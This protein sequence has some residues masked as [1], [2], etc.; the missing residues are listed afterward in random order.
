MAVA[1]LA[2]AATP[3]V[4]AGSQDAPGDRHGWLL[5]CEVALLTAVVA[6]L[7]LSREVSVAGYVASCIAVAGTLAIVL[8]T[9]FAT[10]QAAHDIRI[11]S[12]GLR[13]VSATVTDCHVTGRELGEDDDQVSYTY[14]CTYHWTVDGRAFSEEQSDADA[15]D[16]GR[17][18][19]VWLDGGRMIT[20]RPGGFAILIWIV[21]ALAGLL[22]VFRIGVNAFDTVHRAVVP[23][24]RAEDRGWTPGQ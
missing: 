9:V 1:V 15:S 7:P 8:G 4:W 10:A 13:S 20:Q 16:E 14:S 3:V 12:H 18:V 19:K 23:R 6:S 24:R 5:V 2:V 21:C 17:Q 11:R 22:A